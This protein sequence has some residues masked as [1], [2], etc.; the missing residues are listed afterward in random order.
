M[1]VRHLVEK[2]RGDGSARF[3]WQP[4]AELRACGWRLQRLPDDR[5]EAA[6]RAEALN[7]EVDAWRRGEA[8]PHAPPAA[9]KRRAPA[10]GTVAALIRDY[11]ASRWWRDL[12]P[13]TR[14][15][16]GW[17]LEAIEDWAGDMPAR[18]I[19]PPAVQAWHESLRRR[20]EG[21]GR[22]RRVVET[23]A[24]AAAA[25]RVLRLLLQVGVRL[26][27]CSS[28]AAARPGIAV[29][30]QREPVLWRPDQ[31]EHMVR[32]ADALGWRS[33][34]T[35]ILLNSWIGQ[36]VADVLGLPPWSPEGGALVFRQGK[37]GRRVA[38]PIGLVPALVERLRAEAERPGA[39]RSPTHLLLHDRTGR[40]WNLSTFEH[41]FAEVREAAV[42]GVP[43]AGL[44]PMPD[45][46][47]LLF[48]ELRHTAVTR[49]HE[50]GVDDLGIAGITGHTPGSVRAVLDRHYLVR[51]ERAAAEAFRRRLEAENTP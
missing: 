27:Y 29:E 35:A 47:G 30:R 21:R 12:A 1:R 24:K 8:S 25:L 15:H 45:C 14:R 13:A 36:R 40:P 44:P 34:G 19:T 49:L 6:A 37:T 46:A 50:A 38:L 17:A 20:V 2:R 39:V 51:T 10:P 41:V 9:Q 4:S 43:E 16:Y 33:V 11:R 23:P 28:N 42:R 5:A 18:A 26:G 22:A 31:V 7:A 48:R 3:Y 32:V